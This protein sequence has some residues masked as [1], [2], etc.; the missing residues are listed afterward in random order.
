VCPCPWPLLILLSPSAL[1]E[2]RIGIFCAAGTRPAIAL[3]RHGFAPAPAI[4]AGSRLGICTTPAQSGRAGPAIGAPCG[5]L[6]CV[7]KHRVL[8]CRGLSGWCRSSRDR[9]QLRIW[10][11]FGHPALPAA[12]IF[13]KSGGWV[14]AQSHSD[15]GCAGP[16]LPQGQRRCLWT[17]SRFNITPS[18]GIV[19]AS[20]EFIVPT[21]PCLKGAVDGVR[22][23]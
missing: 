6:L 21:P 23:R 5:W 14:A 4:L 22:A 1:C 10:D 13:Y 7:P 18:R 20:G 19:P 12:F 2:R 9:Q 8:T 15:T 16:A 17:H 3:M 11:R